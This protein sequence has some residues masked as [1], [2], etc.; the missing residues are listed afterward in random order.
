MKK[1]IVHEFRIGDVDDPEIYAA[2]P[3]MNWEKSE[4]G[5]WIMDH[6]IEQ[7]SFHRSADY[8]Y[9]GYKYSIVAALHDQDITYFTLKWGV[10]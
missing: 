5:K 3:I 8:E 9:F 1:I 10:K 4:Q 6:A 7:P 2:E